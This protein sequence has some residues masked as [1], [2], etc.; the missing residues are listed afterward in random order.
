MVQV[1]DPSIRIWKPKT[2]EQE[3]FLQLPD[4]IFE[5]FFGGSV[6]CGKTELLMM[7]PL[8]LGFYKARRFKGLMLRRTFPELESEV[9]QRAKDYYPATGAVWK[10]KIKAYEWPEYNSRMRFGHAQHEKD[11][12]D[13]D[14]DEYQFFAPDELT[15]FTEWM[16]LYIAAT[17]VRRTTE[18][19][20]APICRP[21]GMPGGIGHGWV[22]KRWVEPHKQGGK[23]LKDK[24]GNQ[25]IFIKAQPFRDFDPEYYDR[26][27]LLPQ[28]EYLAKMGDW[29]TFS[30]QVFETWRREPLPDEPINARHVIPYFEIPN[31]W[32]KILAGDIGYKNYFLW[33]AIS[34]DEKLYIYREYWAEKVEVQD[35]GEYIRQVSERDGKFVDVVLDH[36]AFDA[37]KGGETIATLFKRYSGFTP[38]PADKGAGSRVAG[39]SILMDLMR[40]SDTV[41]PRLQVL[42]PVEI[43]SETL[44]LCVYDKK[45]GVETNDVAEF[46][47]DEPYDTVR[48]LARS[49]LNY[50]KTAQKQ[51]NEYMRT[52]QA[53]RKLEITQDQTEFY[54]T[55]ER[56]EGSKNQSVRRRGR[57]GAIRHMQ[58]MRNTQRRSKS[59][60]VGKYRT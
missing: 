5:G 60:T 47:N 34:P 2:Q 41:V 4:S 53:I 19:N 25:K 54:R 18:N 6:K 42:E 24:H 37:S 44:P 8:V 45:D 28:A 52:A 35:Y 48:Y 29:W 36:T 13:Y 16:Y 22:R 39:K 49:F 43:L 46:V 58:S 51:Y 20:L 55:M 14:S 40:W 38:R 17:R 12:K 56:I 31:W 21:G 9:L 15:S 1:T 26:L 3:D 30:G 10:D 59:F 11:I 32:P 27:R 33:G 23:I 50:S 57:I 7:M